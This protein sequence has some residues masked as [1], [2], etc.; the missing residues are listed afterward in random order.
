LISGEIDK[1]R[2]KRKLDEIYD[3]SEVLLNISKSYKKMSN[4]INAMV[5][6]SSEMEKGSGVNLL[7]IHASKGLEFEEV[8]IIDLMEGRFPNRKLIKKM[9]D[10]GSI[11]EERR[12]FYVAVTRAKDKLYLSYAKEDIKRD[13]EFEPSIFLK[14]GASKIDKMD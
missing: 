7:T 1:E 8:Y 2:K 10:L 9:R 4:F 13:K 11:E 12:L 14:E 3:K 6:G 5:L